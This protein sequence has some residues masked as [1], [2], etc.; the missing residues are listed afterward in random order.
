ML[1]VVQR[2]QIVFRDQPVAGVARDHIDFAGCHGH[3]HEIWL[4]LPLLTECKTVGLLDRRP[5][6]PR[7]EFIITG[8]RQRACARCEV[9]DRLHAERLCALARHHQRVGILEPEFASERNFILACER[10]LE[11]LQQLRAGQ[12]LGS[13]KLIDPQRSRIIHIDVDIALG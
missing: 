10:G 9:G 8:N 5:F 7:E 11:L 3:I 6:W 12:D 2:D 4:H 1:W 13:F